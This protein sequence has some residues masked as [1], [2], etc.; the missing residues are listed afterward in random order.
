MKYENHIETNQSFNMNNHFTQFN[1]RLKM[2][3]ERLNNYDILLK[4]DCNAKKYILQ[5]VA[6]PLLE[7]HSVARY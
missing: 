3:N 2:C 4:I 7:K 5:V 6:L 1:K